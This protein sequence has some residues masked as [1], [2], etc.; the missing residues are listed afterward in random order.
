MRP[1]LD[2]VG[3]VV[4]SPNPEL[5]YDVAA[6]LQSGRWLVAQATSGAEALEKVE[7]GDVS[8]ILLDAALP[9][10]RVDEFKELL[11]AE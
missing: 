9:D 2:A 1:P 10:L 5:R 3:L 4:V 11:Q 7:S 6:R 8:L